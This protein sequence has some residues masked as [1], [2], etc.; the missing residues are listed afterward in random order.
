M[1]KFK[2]AVRRR[3]LKRMSRL[4]QSSGPYRKVCRWDGTLASRWSSYVR[5]KGLVFV[6][7]YTQTSAMDA[8]HATD[9][10]GRIMELSTAATTAATTANQMLE[11]FNAGGKGAQ[12][13]RF[14]DGGKLLRTPEVFDTD[15]PVK[16]S[17]WREQF[18]NWLTFCGMVIS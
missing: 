1:V 11:A 4:S 14:G 5:L 6:L 18:L 3:R 13:L 16:Y 2:A 10:L 17:S 7:M 12:A 15:D 8:A 9:L